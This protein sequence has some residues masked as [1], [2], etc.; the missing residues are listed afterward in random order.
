MALPEKGK[1]NQMAKAVSYNGVRQADRT[2]TIAR[3]GQLALNH[4]KR[5]IILQPQLTKA[6]HDKCRNLQQPNARALKMRQLDTLMLAAE[7]SARG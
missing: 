1:L 7:L 2:G 3:A 5:V 6:E 4:P